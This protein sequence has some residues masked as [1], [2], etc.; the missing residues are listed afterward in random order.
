MIKIEIEDIQKIN[1]YIRKY[2]K[3]HAE[4]TFLSDRLKGIESEKNKILESLEIIKSD[5]ESTR[6]DEKAFSEKL[7][8]KYP[9]FKYDIEYIKK[10][11]LTGFDS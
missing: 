5:I 8:K 10:L 11:G 1:S 2:D 3:L 6:D 9:H 4:L 7:K